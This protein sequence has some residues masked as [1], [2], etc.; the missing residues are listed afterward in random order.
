MFTAMSPIRDHLVGEVVVPVGERLH[1]QLDLLGRALG[2][3]RQPL[4]QRP[5]LMR[6]LAVGGFD[7]GRTR[8]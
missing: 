4:L 1:R 3:R 2:H 5:K 6:E 8:S 7:H